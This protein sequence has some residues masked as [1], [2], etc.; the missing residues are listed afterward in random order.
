MMPA[1]D[2][3]ALMVVIFKCS[4]RAICPF[5]IQVFFTSV[6]SER[7]F[8]EGLEAA[9]LVGLVM[10]MILVSP[11]IVGQGGQIFKISAGFACEHIV[12]NEVASWC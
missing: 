6:D 8:L 12:Y 7:L 11:V 4:V 9:H 2:D 1:N 10:G 5:P 3:S